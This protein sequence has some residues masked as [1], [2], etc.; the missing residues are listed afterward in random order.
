MEERMTSNNNL[1][2]GHVWCSI[3]QLYRT[4]PERLAWMAEPCRALAAQWGLRVHT[5]YCMAVAGAQYGPEAIVEAEELYDDSGDAYHDNQRLRSA[6]AGMTKLS[7]DELLAIARRAR[8]ALE[9]LIRVD[10]NAE[11]RAKYAA[12][13]DKMDAWRATNA[14]LAR[15]MLER[16]R[17]VN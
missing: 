5:V 15:A 10:P 8:L 9:R 7:I 4:F 13:L 6:Q 1:V 17:K 2:T 14:A 3:D 12:S 16:K 11:R